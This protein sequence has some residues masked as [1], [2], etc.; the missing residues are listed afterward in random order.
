MSCGAWG[1]CWLRV[2]G[3]GGFIQLCGGIGLR[4]RIRVVLRAP[5]LAGRRGINPVP[6]GGA[7]WCWCWWVSSCCLL[8]RTFL[9]GAQW[10]CS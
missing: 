3:A 5:P 9:P 2:R 10:V 7:L 4:P 6:G 1:C 8:G